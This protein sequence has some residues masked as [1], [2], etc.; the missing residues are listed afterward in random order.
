MSLSP[1]D[2]AEAVTVTFEFSNL[3]ASISAPA[4]SCTVVTGRIDN[5]HQAMIS[6]DPQIIGTKILQRFIGGL[7]GNTYKLRCEIDDA[8]GERWVV[9]DTLVVATA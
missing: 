3:A 4:I 6:G 9:A 2:P 1:K 8:D 7:A 5:S